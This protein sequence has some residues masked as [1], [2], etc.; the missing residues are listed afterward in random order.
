M[1]L[2]LLCLLSLAVLPIA[3]LA[4]SSPGSFP[5]SEHGQ[6]ATVLRSSARGTEY[7]QAT[8]RLTDADA[9]QFCENHRVAGEPCTSKGQSH[10]WVFSANCATGLLTKTS[11]DHYERS[12]RTDEGWYDLEKAELLDGSQA[13][14]APLLDIQFQVLCPDP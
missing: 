6:T 11:T 9:R 10:E 4:Q 14:G 13:S 1:K 5:F 2:A 3:V 7:A 8:V 12:R